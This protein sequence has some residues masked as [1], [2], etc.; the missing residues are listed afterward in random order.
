MD[1]V[2]V[3]T[4]VETDDTSSYLSVTATQTVGSTVIVRCSE[5]ATGLTRHARFTVVG[6][7]CVFELSLSLTLSILI[8]SLPNSLSP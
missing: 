5:G 2:A 8:N 4:G 7:L 1:G 3:T 6:R